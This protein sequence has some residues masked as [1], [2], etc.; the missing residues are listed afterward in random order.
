MGAL[1]RQWIASLSCTLCVAV[2]GAG[3]VWM[4]PLMVTLISDDSPVPMSTADSSWLSSSIEIGQIV[5]TMPCGVLADKIGRKYVI[6]SGGPLSLMAWLLILTTKSIGVLY[7][8]RALQG[9]VSAIAF[10]IVPMYLVEI[11]EPLVRG[12]FAGQLK[13]LWYVG[14]LYA[15][16]TGPYLSYDNYAMVC[17]I[18]SFLFLLFFSFMPESPYYLFMTGRNVEAQKS[19]EWLRGGRTDFT[20]E[21]KNIKHSVEKDMS[22]KATWKDLFATRKDVYVFFLVQVVCLV[23]MFNGLSA[24]VLYATQTFQEEFNGYFSSGSLT[25]FFGL[26]LLATS[27][28]AS[29]LADKVGRRP[30]LIMSSAGS[31]LCH[32]ITTIICYLD[33]GTDVDVSSVKWISYLSIIG[34]CIVSNIGL[35]PLVPTIQAEYFPSH[36]RA[37]GSGLTEVVACAAGFIS[38]KQYQIV[39]DYFGVYMNFFL[40]FIV[41]FLGTILLY[42][43]IPETAG[44]SLGQIQSSFN[45]KIDESSL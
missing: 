41:S 9:V 7:A 30:L 15:Y 32:L 21:L 44:K 10:T 34:F 1:A 38:I 23:K 12:M 18:L 31:A 29:F 6:L 40:F 17:S 26:T 20:L 45:R 27:F 28:V 22:R 37:I 2:A 14:T 8:V 19:L 24:I 16:S 3:F 33:R 25:I 13:V 43:V 36:T 35:G 11:S 42:K 4:A 39:N 5:A